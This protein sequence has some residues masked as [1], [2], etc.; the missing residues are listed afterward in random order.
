MS[1]II[2]IISDINFVISQLIGG[3]LRETS[4]FRGG[5][6]FQRLLP[7][8][9]APLEI[10]DWLGKKRKSQRKPN[11]KTAEKSKAEKTYLR[12]KSRFR[13]IHPQLAGR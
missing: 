9:L 5:A 6:V 1:D 8:R 10:L 2:W 7:V 3:E 13:A 11:K 12:E 4:I